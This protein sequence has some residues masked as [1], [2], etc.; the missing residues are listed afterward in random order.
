MK[1]SHRYRLNRL[2]EKLVTE[3]RFADSDNPYECKCHGRCIKPDGTLPG[4]ALNRNLPAKMRRFSSEDIA[5]MRHEMLTQFAPMTTYEELGMEQR[6]PIRA[7]LAT[8]EHM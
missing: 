5:R 1:N 2:A 6:R 3:E 8:E 4:C 7:T